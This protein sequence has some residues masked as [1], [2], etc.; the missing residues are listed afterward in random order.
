MQKTVKNSVTISGIGLHSN[1]DVTLTIQPADVNHGIVFKRVDLPHL[2][3]EDKLIPALWHNVSDT[4]LCSMIANDHGAVVGTIE[5]LMAALRALGVDNAL[6]EID[7]DE[8]PILDGSS[9]EFIKAIEQA[10]IQTQD[11]P[12]KAIRVM[13]EVTYQDGDRKVTLRPSHDGKPRYKVMIDYTD[14]TIGKQE[15]ELELVNGDFKHDFADC[16][17]FCLYRDIKAMQS[18]GKALGGTLENAIVVDDS[19][20]MNEG[21]L[22]CQNEF[23]RHKLLDAVGDLALAG[24]LVLGCYESERAGHELN[25]KI[26]RALFADEQNYEI[27]D[28]YIE[29]ENEPPIAYGTVKAPSP[30]PTRS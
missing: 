6:I 17:T 4:T 11:A 24:G 8:V 9:Q 25:N 16:R 27:V 20:V 28:H 2:S 14:P 7:A 12:R 13:R 26:L 29:L 18:V 5:H 22:H 19:G 30:A 23:A 21:G 15:A 1:K 3:E 10:G